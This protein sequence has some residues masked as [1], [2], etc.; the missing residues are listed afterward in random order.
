M[1]ERELVYPGS[2][3]SFILSHSWLFG[4]MS[5]HQSLYT[6]ILFDDNTEGG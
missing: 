4:A 3:D 1:V 2:S 5:R 6:M